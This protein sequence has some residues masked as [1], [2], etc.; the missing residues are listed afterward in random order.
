MAARHNFLESDK[1]LLAERVGFHCS[2]PSCGVSTIGPSINANE[3]EYVGVAAHIYSA[4]VDNGP[5]ANPSLTEEQRS[6]ISN[7]IHLCNKCST[8]IDKNNG[9]GYPAEVL[10][11][12]KSYSEEVAKSRVYADKPIVL[13]KKID[14]Q[15]L[16]RDYST[17]LSCSGLNEKNV[18]SCPLNDVVISEITKKLNLANKCV[19]KGCSGSGKSLLT[20]QVAYS[21]YKQGYSIFKISKES[22]SDYLTPVSP[23]A[24]SMLVI[25]DA[26]ILES[27]HLESILSSAHKGC[28]VLANWN[29]S[30]SIDDGFLRN[31]PVVEISPASQV[32]M[33]KEYC[34]KYKVQISE[35]LK[36]LGLKTNK[37]SYHDRIET[38]IYRASRESTPWLFNYS[39]TEGWNAAKQDLDIL[40]SDQKLS[41]VVV[42]VAVF[43]FA[44]LD[45]GANKQTILSALKKFNSDSQWLDKAETVL[46]KYCVSIEGRIKNKH[47][48]YSHRVL[49][50]FLLEKN[51]VDELEYLIDLIATILKTDIYLKGHSNLLEFVMFDFRQGRYEL[52]T[53]GITQEVAL[54]LLANTVSIQDAPAKVTK[55]NSL[56]RLNKDILNLLRNDSS[57]LENWLLDVCR[58]SAYQL[59]NLINTLCN[60]EIKFL[61]VSEMHVKVVFDAMVNAHIEDRPRFAY[62]L[63]RMQFFIDDKCRNY[64]RE[65]FEVTTFEINVSTFSSDT[66]CYQFSKLIDQL[67][68]MNSDW[69]DEQVK[70]NVEGISDLL[71]KDLMNAYDSLE[72]LISHYF[73]VTSAILGIKVSDSRMKKRAKFLASKLSLNSILQAFENIESVDVQSYCNILIFLALYDK[74]K[75]KSVSDKFNYTKLLELYDGDKKLDHYHRGL[76]AILQNPDSKNYQDYVTKTIDKYKYIDDLFVMLLPDYSLQQ[77]K[78]GMRYKMDF[79]G[80]SECRNELLILSEIMKQEDGAS[81]V[82][83]ILRENISKISDAIFNKATNVDKTKSKFSLLIF[84]HKNLPNIF[85]EIFKD[86]SSQLISKICRLIKG[87]KQEKIFAQFYAFLLINYSNHHVPEIREIEKKYPSITRFDIKQFE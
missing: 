43:Q 57:I 50:I 76:I 41:L 33:L 27:K 49:K 6:N 21:F 39:L 46:S 40:E 10:L 24:K 44:T 83:R 1:R 30:T 54:N 42:T 58:K 2:N 4:S 82:K 26:Q 28:L 23:Q 87:T 45:N 68:Y 67:A 84:I 17:A 15:F 53:R 48:E 47:Y 69:A 20:Y 38:R 16:E 34:L 59:G 70:N 35:T 51:S 75:L 13:F 7:A 80:R 81:L 73:G 77:I 22:F 37:K 8:L 66:A 62:L 25:D 65:L 36:L 14:F 5:R 64:Q 32:K 18:E 11:G 52:N 31:Y 56:I 12:W 29:S 86:K 71:N 74:E 85:D 63:N 3:R 19:L 79:G 9:S 60:E 55:L 61:S 78:N 72:D